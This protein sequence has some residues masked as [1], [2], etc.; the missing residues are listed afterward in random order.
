M[1][2]AALVHHGPLDIGQAAQA[3]RQFRAAQALAAQRLGVRAQHAAVAQGGSNGQRQARRVARRWGRSAF[4]GSGGLHPA[5]RAVGPVLD[6]D[7]G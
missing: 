5:Q 1:N 2:A 6:D 7:A 4:A 3:T